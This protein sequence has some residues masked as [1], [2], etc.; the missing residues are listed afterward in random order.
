MG[1]GR[2]R[3]G[4]QPD[5]RHEPAARPG[6]KPPPVLTDDELRRLLKSCEGR[7]FADRRDA[8][9][10][11]LFLDAW[12]CGSPRRPGSCSLATSTWTTRWSSCSARAAG[13]GQ[14]PSAARP[15]LP[16]TATCACGQAIR[17]PHLSNLWL[18]AAGA[19][20]PSG[21]YQSS[22]LV[23]RRRTSRAHPHQFR[24]SFADSWLA[25][26]SRVT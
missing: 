12:G 2:G 13:P 16:W 3:A 26:S 7:D 21:L 4:R 25:G 22:R 6:R 23:G 14:S 8:A 18:G 10:L 5:G 15:P 20:T 1:G 24:H 17:S 11:R 9:I 19:M